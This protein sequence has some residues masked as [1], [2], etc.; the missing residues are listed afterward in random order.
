MKP[1]K[2]SPTHDKDSQDYGGTNGAQTKEANVFKDHCKTTD[3]AGSG[4][5]IESSV[6]REIFTL[7]LSYLAG[8]GDSL[9][10]PDRQYQKSSKG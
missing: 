4:E 8:P 2:P 5:D 3:T 1:S 9:H 6:S 7:P 10:I